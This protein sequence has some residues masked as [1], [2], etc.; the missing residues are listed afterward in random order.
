MLNNPLKR[1]DQSCAPIT[2]FHTCG[3]QTPCL[4]WTN[5]SNCV[6]IIRQLASVSCYFFPKCS[7]MF[8]L[9]AAERPLSPYWYSCIPKIMQ[10]NKLQSYNYFKVTLYIIMLF[11][12]HSRR[13]AQIIANCPPREYSAILGPFRVS[14]GFPAQQQQGSPPHLKRQ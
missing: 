8:W 1:N 3:P 5:V 7:A 11:A 12:I 2:L 13:L 6:W 14:T 4:P 9:G 10:T